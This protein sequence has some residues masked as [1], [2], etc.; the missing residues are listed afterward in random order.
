M[1]LNF[2]CKI[3]N[4]ILPGSDEV[5]IS[6]PKNIH[7]Q[8][9]LPFDAVYD[10]ENPGNPRQQKTRTHP[11]SLIFLVL[12]A[13]AQ[14]M[15]SLTSKLSLLQSQTTIIISLRNHHPGPQPTARIDHETL[16]VS[17]CA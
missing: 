5:Q 7:E 2:G 16:F 3:W 9:E 1:R 13:K 4:L 17:I 12:L 14:I 15:A 10:K 11:N 8:I 6:S